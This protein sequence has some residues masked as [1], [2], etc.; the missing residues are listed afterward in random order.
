MENNWTYN[1]ADKSLILANAYLLQGNKSLAIQ[2]ADRAISASQREEVLLAAAFVYLNANEIGKAREIAGQ[3]SK[4]FYPEVLAYAKLLGGELSLA[5]DDIPSAIN[6]FQE[7]QSHVDTWLGHFLLGRAYL[8]GGAFTEA[9]SEFE[10]C[11]KRQGEAASLFLN[12]LPSFRY[13]PPIHYYLGRAQ[14][15]LESD[16]AST[17]YQ[18]FLQIKEKGDEDWM[19]KDTRR[20]L[21]VN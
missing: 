6:L 4:Q 20:R 10:T 14:E 9:Y 21:S 15:G 3:L 12:D 16:A 13:L 19:V 8:E 11:L 1:A 17:S 7:A 5:R 18:R 2:G